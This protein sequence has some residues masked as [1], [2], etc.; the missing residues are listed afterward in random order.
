MPRAV[1]LSPLESEK[2]IELVR[3]NPVLYDA[4]SS[5]HKDVQLIHNTWASIADSMGKETGK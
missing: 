5:D 4:R 3:I 2:L 1:K